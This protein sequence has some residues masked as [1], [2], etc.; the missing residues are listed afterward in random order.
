MK[1]L[2]VHFFWPHESN[3]FRPKTLHPSALIFYVCLLLLVQVSFRVIKSTHPEILGYATD[4]TIDKLL[5]LTNLER[6]RQGL[7]SLNPDS[8][9]ST[10][11]ASKANDM[12][13]KGYWSHSAPDGTSP[14]SFF[15]SSGY[16][17]VYAGENLAR[18]FNDSESVVSAWMASQTHKDNILKPEYKDIGFAVIN[19]K[20]NGQETTLVV[21]FFGTR[22]SPTIAV[23]PVIPPVVATVP[24]ASPASASPT[25]IPTVTPIPTATSL[26]N[27]EGPE[28][29]ATTLSIWHPRG[30]S[31]YPL[32]DYFSASKNFA[33]LL[34]GFLLGVLALDGVFIWR[35]K[36]V[37]VSGH[38]FA[39]IIFLV[40]LLGVIWM[41]NQ[42]A[43]L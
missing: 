18:D 1:N 19:G 4:I 33:T 43:I 17:F 36:I 20:L 8:T 16:Q 28:G 3:N 24:R 22:S 5:N 29:P 27:K 7:P 30:V 38:N 25:P 9:L 41:T 31:R 23:K 6:A 26:V 35:R 12:F 21:Q 32:I 13:A 39:H 15:T 10:A 42:G 14:W 2:L 34:T 11:A 40:C 37:R